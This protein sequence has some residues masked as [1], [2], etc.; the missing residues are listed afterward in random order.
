MTGQKIIDKIIKRVVCG[1]KPQTKNKRKRRKI[2]ELQENQGNQPEMNFDP[3]TGEPIVNNSVNPE[4][5]NSVQYDA[6]S[7]GSMGKKVLGIIC[8]IIG[9]ISNL[10]IFTA[11]FLPI[12]NKYYSTYSNGKKKTL[13]IWSY[14]SE[15]I[16]NLKDLDKYDAYFKSYIISSSIIDMIVV[17]SIIALGIFALVYLIMYIVDLCGKGNALKR[18][19]SNIVFIIIMYAIQ[20]VFLIGLEKVQDTSSVYNIINTIVIIT[21]LI[22][23]VICNYIDKMSFQKA[24]KLTYH[25]QFMFNTLVLLLSSLG[26][27]FIISSIATDSYKSKINITHIYMVANSGI[28]LITSGVKYAT[29]NALKETGVVIPVTLLIFGVI[30]LNIKNLLA[31]MKNIRTN[32]NLGAGVFVRSIVML[33]YLVAA[34]IVISVNNKKLRGVKKTPC[35]FFWVFMIISVLTIIIWI[36]KK[37]LEKAAP[38]TCLELEENSKAKVK[39]NTIKAIGFTSI[40][41]VIIASLITVSL[42]VISSKKDEIKKNNNE[43]S[44]EYDDEDDDDEDDDDYDYDD[45]DYDYDEDDYDYDEDDYDYDEDDY[46]YDDDDRYGF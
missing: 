16:K 12:F 22:T 11:T 31:S 44:Y 5:L 39:K 25:L 3:Y 27:F 46:D 24:S 33:V 20:N 4:D 23:Y 6:G 2:M 21:L 32:F 42:V 38:G 30:V 14:I 37:I 35:A 18:L 17:V 45:D 41:A 7:N 43:F 19:T 9:I 26:L 34:Q 1:V 13:F 40:G 8:A 28:C 15:I 10:A 36:V 29:M